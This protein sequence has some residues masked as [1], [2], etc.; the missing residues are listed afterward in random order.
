MEFRQ[1]WTAIS[2]TPASW[3]ATPPTRTPRQADVHAE[4]R[5][6]GSS[7]RARGESENQDVQHAEEGGGGHL[8]NARIQEDALLEE[9]ESL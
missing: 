9:N 7:Q 2:A 4:S 8:R 3:Q 6:H 1:V 5:H